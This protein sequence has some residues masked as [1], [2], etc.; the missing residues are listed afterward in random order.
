ME[1]EVWE[2]SYYRSM[3]RRSWVDTAS[4]R[5]VLGVIKTL[6]NACGAPA[7]M[8]GR[9]STLLEIKNGRHGEKEGAGTGGERRDH[10]K[11]KRCR[12]VETVYAVRLCSKRPPS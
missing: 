1:A 4:W 5:A 10:G 9:R 11:L 3:F 6:P 2:S 8:T 12:S 7:R